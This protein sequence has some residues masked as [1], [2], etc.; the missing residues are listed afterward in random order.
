VESFLVAILV[1]SAALAFIVGRWWTILVPIAA[2]G[3]FYAGLN[4][5]WW[6]SGVGDGWQFVMAIAMVVGGLAAAG[7]VT[8]RALVRPRAK[9]PAPSQAPR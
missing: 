2:L 4:Y 3:V 7:G 9:P 1:A 5:G 8:M 6:G